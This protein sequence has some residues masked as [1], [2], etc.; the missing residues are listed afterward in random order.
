MF[1]VLFFLLA[2]ILVGVAFHK[3]TWL[4]K[5][6]EKLSALAIYLLLFTLGIKAGSDRTIMSRLDTLGLTALGISLFAIAGS[7][8]TAWV[9]YK[10]FFKDLKQ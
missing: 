1:N 4:P 7:V 8:L 6:S 10:Y 9:V 3:R 5:I 2:G